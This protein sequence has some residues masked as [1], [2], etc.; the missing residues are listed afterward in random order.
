MQRVV[1]S[2]QTSVVK[3]SQNP[4]EQCNN[5]KFA[6][7]Q[8]VVFRNFHNK[9]NDEV[10][11]NLNTLVTISQREWKQVNAFIE[12]LDVF[13]KEQFETFKGLIN[14][15]KAQE[16]TDETSTTNDSASTTGEENIFLE[17]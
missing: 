13:H 14:K 16:T 12:E 1:L 10:K 4:K 8:R 7:K 5:G 2:R 17:K 6:E 15:G 11:A 9:R 3:C